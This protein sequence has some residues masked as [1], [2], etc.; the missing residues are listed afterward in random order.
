[1]EAAEKIPGRRPCF[2]LVRSIWLPSND[3]M[4]I[5]QAAA[6]AGACAISWFCLSQSNLAMQVACCALLTWMGQWT[7][8][9][10]ARAVEERA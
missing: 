10:V 6:A 5:T 7:I 1:M 2:V 3:F 8:L 4:L 9:R